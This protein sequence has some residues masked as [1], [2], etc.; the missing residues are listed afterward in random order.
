MKQVRVWAQ[1]VRQQQHVET[2]DVLLILAL[3]LIAWGFAGLFDARVSSV[4][5][6]GILLVYA[7]PPRTPS[8]EPSAERIDR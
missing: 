4:V 3:G 1:W 8:G 5:T 6:G 2:Q 7:W